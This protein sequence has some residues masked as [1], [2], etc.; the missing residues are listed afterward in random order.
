MYQLLAH[1]I[2]I[3]VEKNLKTARRKITKE[4]ND[5]QASEASHK[6]SSDSRPPENPNRGKRPL[7][8]PDLPMP[9][10]V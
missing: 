10:L 3:L 7:G 5:K 1:Y 9:P 8:L 6:G 2:S 4:I